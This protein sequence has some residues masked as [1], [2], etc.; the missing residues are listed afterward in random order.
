MTVNGE[1]KGGWIR[2]INYDGRDG[3]MKVVQVTKAKKEKARKKS[4]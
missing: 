3:G 4:K 2:K 1:G